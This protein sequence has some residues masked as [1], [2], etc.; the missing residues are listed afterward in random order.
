MVKKFE[1]WK[2]FK[3]KVPKI[4]KSHSHTQK[5]ENIITYIIY[6]VYISGCARVEGTIGT[7]FFFFFIYINIRDLR[8][9]DSS[10]TAWNYLGTIGTISCFFGDSSEIVPEIVPG[11][12]AAFRSFSCGLRFQKC[13][14]GYFTGVVGGP[15][16]DPLLDQFVGQGRLGFPRV[17]VAF[18]LLAFDEGDQGFVEFA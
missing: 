7:I 16:N 17:Q 11:R 5:R 12:L 2:S 1:K 18:D 6:I 13:S 4:C 14:L 8:R 10:Q 3:Q 9:K 15:W